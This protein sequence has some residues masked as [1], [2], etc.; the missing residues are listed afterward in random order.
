M[1]AKC[2]KA[3]AR[4]SQNCLGQN[5]SFSVLLQRRICTQCDLA[6]KGSLHL[7][8][9]AACDLKVRGGRA[10]NQAPMFG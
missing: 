10:S 4:V 6:Q 5:Y 3:G 2:L 7:F 9:P 1:F 8:I